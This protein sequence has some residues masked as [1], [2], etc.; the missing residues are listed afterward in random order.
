MACLGLIQTNFYCPNLSSAKKQTHNTH[1]AYLHTSSQN[2]SYSLRF[3]PTNWQKAQFN[4][5]HELRDSQVVQQNFM[6]AL[7]IWS[8]RSCDIALDLTDMILLRYIKS[9]QPVLLIKNG[10]L[11]IIY[12]VKGHVWLWCGGQSDEFYS[13][14]IKSKFRQKV[15]ILNLSYLYK[16]RKLVNFLRGRI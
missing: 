16:G 10:P 8:Q 6:F 9:C 15:L 14:R 3:L 5:G 4:V 2:C 12:D 1:G 7:E 13:S 11:K